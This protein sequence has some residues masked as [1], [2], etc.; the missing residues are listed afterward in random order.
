MST[1]LISPSSSDTAARHNAA[2]SDWCNSKQ[3]ENLS[4]KTEARQVR[5]RY[6]KPLVVVVDDEMVVAVTLS[7]VLRRK[8][9]DA[10]W[11]DDSMEALAYVKTGSVDLLLSDINMPQMDGVDL[12]M[13]VHT[14]QP[15][16]SLFLFSAKADC[17]SV[18]DRVFRSGL[19]I[20]LESKPLQVRHLVSIVA[21]LLGLPPVMQRRSSWEDDGVLSMHQS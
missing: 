17:P 15:K 7:E 4:R 16:C 14:L 12:A 18:G 21:Q 20:H 3:A 9:Y 10:V 1:G 8:G 19:Q 13:K 6:D 2:Y 11:F 5:S